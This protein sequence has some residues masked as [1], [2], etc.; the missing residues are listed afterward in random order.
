MAW[1]DGGFS[2]AVRMTDPKPGA[3]PNIATLIRRYGPVLASGLIMWAVFGLLIW[4]L[5]R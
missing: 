5:W 4:K 2:F 1:P 3:T